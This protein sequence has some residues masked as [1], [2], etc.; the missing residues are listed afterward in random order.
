MKI[1]YTSKLFYKKYAFKITLGFQVAKRHR[2]HRNKTM[3]PELQQVQDW[4][5]A[6][7][8]TQFK[9]I[10]RGIWGNQIYS[11][12]T[13]IYVS[14]ESDKDQVLQQYASQ[15]LE[16]WQP[17]D[18]SHLQALG[19]RNIT[20]V[21]TRLIYNK[22]SHVIYFKYDKKQTL[23]GQLHVM[24]ADSTQSAVKGCARWP[25]VY[26]MC[27]QDITWIRLTYPEQ[28]DYVK[29]VILFPT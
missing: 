6:T 29:H 10:N 24:L 16:V 22:Y 8:G 9:M 17:W 28:I 7:F 21:R 3:Q 19:V 12:E 4:C 20:Q 23:K 18:D 27:E 2:Y 25:R 13:S 26:S 14:S 11:C 1:N 15:V 5:V